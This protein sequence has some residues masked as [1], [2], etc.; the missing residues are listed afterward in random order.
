MN[1]LTTNKENV[2]NQI[3]HTKIKT[4]EDLQQVIP[5]RFIYK[6]LIQPTETKLSPPPLAN[7][8]FM[9]IKSPPVPEEKEKETEPEVKATIHPPFSSDNYTKLQSICSTLK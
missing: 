8:I 7:D 5:T 6:Y 3:K 9:G 4:L 1:Y 2:L